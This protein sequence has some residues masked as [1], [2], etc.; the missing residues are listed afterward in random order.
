MVVPTVTK[1]EPIPAKN[2]QKITISGKDMD[3]VSG[4]SFGG[5][6]SGTINKKSA[7]E[8]EVTVPLDATDGAS[9]LSTQNAKSVTTQVIN[10]VKPTITSFSPTSTQALKP[11]VISGTHLDLV[12]KIIFGGDKVVDINNSNEKSLTVTVPSGTLTGEF[13]I[14]T[15]N[16]TKIKSEKPLN[17]IASNVPSVTGYP[18]TA[19]PGQLITLTGTK[20]NLLTDVI[21]PNNIKASTFGTKTDTKIEVVVPLNVKTG[22]GKIKFMTFENEVS[23]TDEILF[24]GI[25]PVKDPSLVFFNFDGRNAWWG[26]MQGNTRKDAES[27]DGSTYGFINENLNGWNDL[28]WRNSSNDFPGNVIGTKVNEYVLKIDINIKE[29]L[30]GGNFKFRL[31]GDEG[32]FWFGIGPNSPTGGLKITKTDGWETITIKITDFKD[33]FGWGDKT[34]KNMASISKEFGMAW[35]DGASKVNVLIDNVRFEKL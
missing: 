14:E 18:K 35:N 23:E 27:V 24:A 8:I 1:I 3:L 33:N 7:T 34:I 9:I 6:K 20:M 26:K 17:L 28:F 10:L 13:T 21:F 4:I 19:K 11:I 2:G 22:L 5:N 31:N 25:D 29:P 32:D 12:K 15:S 30:V 16:G